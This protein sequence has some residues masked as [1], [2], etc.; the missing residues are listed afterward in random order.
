MTATGRQ[1]HGQAGE[2]RALEYLSSHGLTLVERNFRCKVGEIDLIMQDWQNLVFVEV[3]R[4]DSRDFGG[5]LASVT[6]VKQRR[7]VRAAQFYLLRYK[8]LP[9]CRFDVIAI[10]GDSLQWLRNAIVEGM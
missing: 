4:R 2:D 10:D 1:L 5:A 7:M 6:P 3:R 9:P 8:K